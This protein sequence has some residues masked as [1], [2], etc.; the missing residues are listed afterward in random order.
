MVGK[1]KFGLNALEENARSAEVPECVCV[2]RRVEGCGG[3]VVV[4]G[5][6]WRGVEVVLWCVEV[7]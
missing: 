2:W 3:G 7:V 6:V 1:L 4:C 5:G